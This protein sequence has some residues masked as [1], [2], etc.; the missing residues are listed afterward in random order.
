M[1]SR[2]L[3]HYWRSVGPKIPIHVAP[4]ELARASGVMV[5]IHLALLTEL[6]LSPSPKLRIVGCE[7]LT[8]RRRDPQR[9]A[10]TSFSLRFSALLCVSALSPV[11]SWLR[12]G[13]A[14]SLAPFRGY[15]N[16]VF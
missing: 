14:A 7:D 4:T 3:G 8:Q 13:R 6:D 1:S 12:L 5:T 10:E 9:S 15:F 16:S 11:S 2:S